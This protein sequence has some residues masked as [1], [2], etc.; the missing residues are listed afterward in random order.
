MRATLQLAAPLTLMIISCLGGMGACASGSPTPAPPPSGA[1][2]LVSTSPQPAP[3]AP[4]SSA[5]SASSASPVASASGAASASSA[6]AK[7]SGLA[8]I[9]LDAKVLEPLVRTELVKEFLAAAWALPAI[10]K[11]RLYHDV[12]KTRYWSEAEAKRLSEAEQRALKVREVDEEFFYNTNY[13]TPLAY[14]RPLDLLGLGRDAM[15]GKKIVDFGFGGIGH[16]R[17]LASMG[18]DV[19]GIEVD[20]M[21]RALYSEPGDQGLIKGI[22]GK[23]GHLRLLFG[24]FPAEPAIRDAVGD[25]YDLFISKNVLK[26]GYI[27]PEQPVKER[28]QIKLGVD[29]ATFVRTVFAKL[30]PGGRFMI[31]NLTPAPNMPGKPY[32][33]WADG[34]CP[35]PKQMLEAVGFRVVAYNQEDSPAAR[36]QGR[37]LGWDKGEE[38]MDLEN[39]LFGQ[40][41]LSEKPGAKK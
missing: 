11:R 19:T 1:D 22:R 24:Q 12:E 31:Y 28:H 33:T 16:L 4:G 18:A 35:F 14:S 3:V 27:H 15:S 5:A 40:Y 29:D 9:T 21:L 8:V 36:A 17:M 2:A 25:G 32:R 38:P 39:D 7:P 23:D 30:K 37:A 26:Y 13:G 20:P 6:L 41:T 34:R 10:P